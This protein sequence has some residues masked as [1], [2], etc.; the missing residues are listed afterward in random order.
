MKVEFLFRMARGKLMALPELERNM[1]TNMRNQ[2]S[3]EMAFM[4]RR[5]VEVFDKRQG[6]AKSH[7]PLRSLGRMPFGIARVKFR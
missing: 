4:D 7:P 6:D 5:M 3:D 2:F 1:N